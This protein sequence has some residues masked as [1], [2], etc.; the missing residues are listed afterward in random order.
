VAWS[1]ALAL[2]TIV[3]EI[4]WSGLESE[5]NVAVVAGR[6]S[7]RSRLRDRDIDAQRAGRIHMKQLAWIS[8][9]RAGIDKVSDVGVARSDDAIKRRMIR[10]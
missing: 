1:M 6:G 8:R 5:V 3:P 10:S 7:S 2:R 4:F 9:S